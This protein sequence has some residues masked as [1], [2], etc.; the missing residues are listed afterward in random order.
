MTSHPSELASSYLPKLERNLTEQILDF[1]HPRCLDDE[2]GG[3]LLHYDRDGSATGDDTKMIVTQARMVWFFSRLAREGYGSGEYLDAAETGYE[4]L[5][6]EFW[7]ADHE[8]FYWEVERSGDVLKPNKHL[9]GQAFGIYALVEYHRA[10]GREA[11]LLLAE[12]LFDRIDAAAYDEQY[13]GYV[14]Y[15]T[16][17]WTPIETGT[18]YLENIEPDWSE[19]ES[20][21]ASLDP[22]L[23]LMN[24]HLHLLEAFTELARASDRQVV[25]D[26]LSEL[27]SILTTTV[28][29]PDLNAC[30]DKYTREWEPL[31]EG[32]QFQI[33][34]YGHDVE[35]IWLVLEACDALDIP[36]PL[37][38]EQFEAIFEYTL[39]H[40]YD[41]DDGGFY[42]FGPFDE[43][44]TNEIKAWWVQAEGLV[45]ALKMYSLTGDATYLSVF[46]ETY[47]FVEEHQLDREV[48]EWHSGVD[49]ALNPVGRKGANYKGAYHNGRAM[50]ECID[51]LSKLT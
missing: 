49:A 20:E 9:Y 45:S 42:F 46:E 50:L 17:E 32:E 23:K 51:A 18:T 35:T 41:H 36:A 15:F 21:A 26:R 8:G 47:D 16:P 13:G 12:D 31:V 4:F 19:K 5:V 3:Y 22:T 39:Q 48:G 28:I 6:S 27:L 7:D 10:T 44:A 29:R 40:G 1:W 2:H 30:T 34:S 38:A 43:A 11:P 14:E 33:V 37:F 24:T 25:R